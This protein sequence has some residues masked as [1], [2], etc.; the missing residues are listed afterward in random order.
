VVFAF[1]VFCF[2]AQEKGET[3]KKGRLPAEGSRPDFA[4]PDKGAKTDS[5]FKGA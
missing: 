3:Q 1:C 4:D 2:S 5:R